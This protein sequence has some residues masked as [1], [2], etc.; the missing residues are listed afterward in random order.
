MPLKMTA[1][2]SLDLSGINRHPYTIGL[3]I[4]GELK[5]YVYEKQ[6]SPFDKVSYPLGEQTAL[7]FKKN[8]PSVFDDVKELD[9]K[10]PAQDVV[11]ILEPSIVKFSSVIPSPAYNPY[12][13]TMIYRIDVYDNAGEKIFTQTAI[14][15]AQTSK[16]LL[17]GFV[18]RSLASE[19]AQKAME[20]AVRQIIEGLSEAEELKGYKQ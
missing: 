5:E 20:N 7:L 6:T 2:E 11:L 16:G 17:S 14:G 19:V 4:P 3:F 8:L 12:T 10:D 15:E 13:A 9:S 18:A 1:P